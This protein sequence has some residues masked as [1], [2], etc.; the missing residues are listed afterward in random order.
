MKN[1]LYKL[2]SWKPWSPYLYE[3]VTVSFHAISFFKFKRKRICFKA[4][5]QVPAFLDECVALIPFKI[6]D[7]VKSAA[8]LF[9][10]H[11]YSDSACDGNVDIAR[12]NIFSYKTRDEE[13]N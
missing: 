7:A 12:L 11:L 9:V 5:K 3:H 4:T 1:H 6:T 8:H 2:L 10:C 13:M